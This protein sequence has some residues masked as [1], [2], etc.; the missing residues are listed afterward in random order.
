[1]HKLLAPAAALVLAAC[2]PA[3][4]TPPP[5]E[6][7]PASPQD[8]FFANLSALCGQSFEGEVVT[9]DA[10][11]AAFATSHLLM[12][13]RDCSESEIRIPFWVGQDRSRTWIVTR[14][15]DGLRLKH[16]HRH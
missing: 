5:V 1:M 2:S 8:A 6:A 12:H 13:V 16:D 7:T 9:N 10:A 11:D 3:G 4:E 14:T 15:G